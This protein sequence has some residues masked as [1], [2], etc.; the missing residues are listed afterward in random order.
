MD[1]EKNTLKEHYKAIHKSGETVNCPNCRKKIIW[2]DIPHVNI[3]GLPLPVPFCNETCKEQFIGGQIKYHEDVLR[4]LYKLKS[5]AMECPNCGKDALRFLLREVPFVNNVG[6]EFVGM[7]VHR[8]IIG[9]DG[10]PIPECFCNLDKEN[11]RK[12]FG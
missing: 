12:I 9:T 3:P 6:E 10:E 7:A 8:E 1:D 2:K 4:G 5:G 11:W